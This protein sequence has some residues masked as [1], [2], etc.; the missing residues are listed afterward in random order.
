M[1]ALQ[2]AFAISSGLR[3]LYPSPTLTTSKAFL[4]GTFPSR[5]WVGCVIDGFYEDHSLTKIDAFFAS[6]L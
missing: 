2:G 6:S 4:L 5:Q 3:S 1:L